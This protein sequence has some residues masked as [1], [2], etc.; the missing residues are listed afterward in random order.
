[1]LSTFGNTGTGSSSFVEVGSVPES[2]MLWPT[3]AAIIGLALHADRMRRGR[4][5]RQ[6]ADYV[7]GA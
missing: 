1:V 7:I 2:D 6:S 5:L 3:L 4:H